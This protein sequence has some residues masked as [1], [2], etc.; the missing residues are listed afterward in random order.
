MPTKISELTNDANFVSKTE[1]ENEYVKNTAVATNTKLGLVKVT[2]TSGIELK[3][4][5]SIYINAASNEEIDAKTETHRPIVPANLNYAV[6]S[7]RPNISI[8]NPATLAA[9]T[10]YDLGN[11]TTLSIVLPSGLI[12]DFIQVDFLSGDTATTLTISSTSGLS[13]YDL[14]PEQNTIYSLYFDWG[15]LY[16]DSTNSAYVYGWRF[17][18]SEYTKTIGG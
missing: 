12:G 5:G 16:Y 6:R 4:D 9:N 3:E 17:G 14:I 2:D 7:V 15:V 8:A 11:Q 10:I 18:Y 13:D 1:V